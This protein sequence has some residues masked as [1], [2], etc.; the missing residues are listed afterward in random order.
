MIADCVNFFAAMFG[1]F[2]FIL[3]AK[4]VKDIPICSLIFFMNIHFMVMNSILA[5]L[6]ILGNGPPF[7]ISMSTT[8]GMFGFLNP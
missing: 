6:N 3:S 4:N 2:Y 1:A 8:A 7:E 5:S